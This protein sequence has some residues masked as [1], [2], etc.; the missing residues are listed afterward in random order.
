VA[1]LLVLLV[2]LAACN[3]THV[4]PYRDQGSA[5]GNT[6]PYVRVVEIDIDRQFFKDRPE[7]VL[8]L[9]MPAASQAVPFSE[10]MEKYLALHLGFRFGRVIHGA[11]R[12]RMATRE[13][14]DLTERGDRIHF[15]EK[16]AC[17]YEIEFRLIQAQSVFVLVWAQLSL[18]L[19]V[20]L[21][22]ARDGR[23]LWQARHTA[24]RSDG[25]IAVSPLG[26]ITSAVE[27]AALA[28]DGE[29]V[30]SLIADVTR[31][32]AA[33]LPRRNQGYKAY[34]AGKPAPF[35]RLCGDQTAGMK[36]DHATRNA[37]CTRRLRRQTNDNATKEKGMAIY[38]VIYHDQGEPWYGLHEV[39]FGDDGQ[40]TWWNREPAGFKGDALDGQDGLAQV[41][42]AAAGDAAR[43]PALNGSELPG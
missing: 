19:E 31:R 27:A 3:R 1:R 30:V 14:L 4:A 18:G 42:L 22:R 24:S 25:G 40:V 15:H 29:Q 37:V 6:V 23:V 17:G 33:T 28:S 21:T 39:K 35:V 34:C 7:C 9:P 10:L 26:A 36:G 5:D 20:R 32:I 13:G 16:E 8:V 41:L 11:V 12:D 2:A 38:R 43:W